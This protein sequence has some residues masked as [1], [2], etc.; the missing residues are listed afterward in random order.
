MK[1][2]ASIMEPTIEK[3]MEKAEMAKAA[4]IIEVR[5]D[6]LSEQT[7]SQV[8]EL[9]QS[10]KRLGN[11]P[12]ILTNRSKAEGGGF[13]GSEEARIEILLQCL[14]I[15][16]VVD[17]EFS[18]EEELRDNAIVKAKEKGIEV[19]VSHHDFERTPSEEEMMGTLEKML[20]IGADMAKMAVTANS[21]DDVLRLLNVTRK[22]SKKGKV[23]TIAMGDEGRISRIVAPLMGSEI[24]YASVGEAVAPGQLQ[25]NELKT[26]LEAMK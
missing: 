17:V 6:G 25:L 16:D 18:A 10:I 20:S 5:A 4:D 1:V 8:E 19:I 21:P 14:N 2:C 24:T 22:A 12:V 9:L 11:V 13:N 15:A 3:F 23:I 7:P 26:I